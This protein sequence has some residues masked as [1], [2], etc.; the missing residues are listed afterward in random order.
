[1]LGWGQKPAPHAAFPPNALQ[2]LL[3]FAQFTLR[4]SIGLLVFLI[5]WLVINTYQPLYILEYL[6][7]FIDTVVNNFLRGKIEGNKVI[8]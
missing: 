7:F 1:M 5:G 6:F 3:G 2:K 4:K 8:H